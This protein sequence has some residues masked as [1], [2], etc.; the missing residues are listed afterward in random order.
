MPAEDPDTLRLSKTK[1]QGKI[2]QSMPEKL[3][4]P[5]KNSPQQLTSCQ[6]QSTSGV[7]WYPSALWSMPA[8]GAFTLRPSLHPIIYPQRA[9]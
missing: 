8:L 4:N 1:L 6:K 5:A 2:A 7:F 3:E 9:L